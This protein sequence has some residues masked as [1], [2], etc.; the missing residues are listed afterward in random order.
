MS[1]DFVKGRVLVG[2]IPPLQFLKG[3]VSFVFSEGFLE[4]EALLWRG[5]GRQLGLHA[6]IGRLDVFM[7]TSRRGLLAMV[8]EGTQRE[9]VTD[10]PC[11]KGIGADAWKCDGSVYTHK[12]VD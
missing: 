9:E 3:D 2:W 8:I 7:R 12:S 6:Q 5:H 10:R 11:R 4:V 1:N